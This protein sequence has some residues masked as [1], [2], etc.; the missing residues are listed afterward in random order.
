MKKYLISAIILAAVLILLVVAFFIYQFPRVADKAI[1]PNL[2][3]LNYGWDEWPGVLPYLVANDKGFFSANGLKV[4]MVKIE[5]NSQMVSKL[6]DGQIDFTGDITL[7]DTLKAYSRGENL[8]VINVTDYSNGGDG[9]VAK[10]SIAKVADLKGKRVAVE[11]GSL[12][13]KLL[14]YALEKNDLEL[15]DV[16]RVDLSAAEAAQAFIRGEVDAAVTYEPGLSEAVAA[17]GVKIFSTA[18]T[19][20]L[21]ID[22]G[23]MRNDYINQ[24]PEKVQAVL[25]SYFMGLDYI[26]NNPQESYAIG[27]K[28]FNVSEQ[29]F[30][31]YLS[32]LEW[33][34]LRGNLLSMSY[35]LGYE[36]LYGNGSLANRY[37]REI[38]IISSDIDIGE[39]IR[40]EFVRALT[41]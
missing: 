16:Q 14:F 5:T 27:A 36:S 9:I 33:V 37:L 41:K 19:P 6:I 7:V 8:Q 39:V 3:E 31:D 29:E 12:N 1:V 25:R 21:I 35:S 4:K 38:D 28:Y 2:G 17:G 34:D 23:A 20:G 10:K 32:G 26:K 18:L 13:E 11:L 30:A 24:N 15:R 22:V 40:P